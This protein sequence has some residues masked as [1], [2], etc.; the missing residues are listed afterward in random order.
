[1]N[2]ELVMMAVVAYLATTVILVLWIEAVT[3]FIGILRGII[4]RRKK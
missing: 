2:M 3:G 4:H 1:M